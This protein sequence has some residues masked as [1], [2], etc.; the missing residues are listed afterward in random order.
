MRYD[1][2]RG[3]HGE[4]QPVIRGGQNALGDDMGWSE[5]G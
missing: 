1:N 5:S 2:L 3:V 4:S